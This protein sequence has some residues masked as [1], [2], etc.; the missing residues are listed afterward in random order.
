MV[1]HVGWFDTVVSLG[2]TMVEVRH[3]M[4]LLVSPRHQG[5]GVA[6]SL[7]G[8]ATRLH[9]TLLLGMTEVAEIVYRRR[10][11]RDLGTLPARVRPSLLARRLQF[12][13]YRVPTAVSVRETRVSDDEL[14]QFWRVAAA[15]FPAVALRDAGTIRRR[16]LESPLSS[17]RCWAARRGGV[18]AGWLVA[19]SRSTG[20]IRQGILVDGLVAHG[21]QEAWRALV[22][23]GAM[24]LEDAGASV[25]RMSSGAGW[26]SSML[27]REWFVKVPSR[28]PTVGRAGLR[29]MATG[30][31]S[32]AVP[33]VESW[34][35]TRG[36]GETDWGDLSHQE[37]PNS[38][39]SS[40][41][42]Q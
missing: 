8:E 25:V 12:L 30:P 39:A 41:E 17:Y 18:L 36:D 27:S 29:F 5:K 22:V 10:G 14:D 13:G 32:D 35:L 3:L 20:R 38:D 31:G 4:D 23:A 11:Y 21:D 33:G 15:G 6:S 37:A 40:P 9:L 19:R 24:G 7:L 28:V 1:G 26:V 34:W 42:R 16:Y 2:G